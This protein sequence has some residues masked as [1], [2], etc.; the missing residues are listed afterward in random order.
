MHTTEWNRA[1][2]RDTLDAI[3][4]RAKL[5]QT[6]VGELAGRDRTMANRWL[7]GK[8]QPN[9]EA[10][11]RFAAAIAEQ[12]PD[13]ADLA[14]QF[15]IAAGYGDRITGSVSAVLPP[16]EASATGTSDALRQAMTDLRA[17]AQAQGRPLAEL[18]VE[19]GIV[20][21]DE[22]VVPDSLRPDPIIEEINASSD[23]SEDTK[24][25]LIRAHLENRARRFEEE[26]LK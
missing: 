17:Q 11:A 7:S 6:A 16:L 8:H 2:L 12:R 22:L 10:A 13:L 3:M 18:L 19:E 24:I 9:Y 20:T 1:A 5:S 21:P 25:A 26:R 23:L 4:D 14:Q 15:M